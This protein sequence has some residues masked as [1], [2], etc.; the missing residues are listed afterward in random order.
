MPTKFSLVRDIN[1][2]NGFGLQFSDTK[3][4]ATL[5][6]NTD[7]TLTVPSSGALG[8]SKTGLVDF[9]VAIFTFAPSSLTWVANNATAGVPAGASFA[10]TASEL[11]PVARLVKGGDVLHFYSPGVSTQVGVVFYSLS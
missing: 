2:Y 9:W 5:T 10:A 3:Y 1:G 7:T 11:N 4:S 6:Q 8:G